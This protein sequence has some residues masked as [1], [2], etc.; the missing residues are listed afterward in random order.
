MLKRLSSLVT[1]LINLCI[2]N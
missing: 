2:I 1:I